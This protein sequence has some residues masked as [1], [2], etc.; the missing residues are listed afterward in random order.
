MLRFCAKYELR[1][2][3]LNIIVAEKG[4][5]FDETIWLNGSEFF[6]SNLKEQARDLSLFPVF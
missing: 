3:L 4:V 1:S 2:D 5:P 6:K